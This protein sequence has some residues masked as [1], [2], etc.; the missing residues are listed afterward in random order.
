MTD[1]QS[2]CPVCPN[3]SSKICT[4]CH[5]IKY[6]SRECQKK[7]WSVHSFVCQ[8]F[9]DIASRPGEG[10]RRAVYFPVSGNGLE[11]IWLPV[12]IYRSQ[13]DEPHNFTNPV[14]HGNVEVELGALLGSDT[15]VPGLS[16]K[17]SDLV[18]GKSLD[19][20]IVFAY[21]NEFHF[22]GSLSNRSIDKIQE[23]QPRDAHTTW[24]GPVLAYG[25]NGGGEDLATDSVDL[26][27]TD[28]RHIVDYLMDSRR[29]WQFLG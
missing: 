25:L 5:N 23:R 3:P 22:D 18:H 28:F 6:C 27:T 15:R 21:R 2:L 11:L 26:D 8:K 7:D 4:R 14:D 17:C 20:T 1:S 13:D 16:L 24:K 19:H 10:Y 9:K 29:W 12:D